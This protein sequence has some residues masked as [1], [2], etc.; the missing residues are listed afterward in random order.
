MD[1]N[2]KIFSEI[3]KVIYLESEFRNKLFSHAYDKGGSLAG[4]GVIMGYLSRPGLN[5][6]SRDM[7]LGLHGIPKDRIL[8]LCEAIDFSLKEVLK[9]TI[10]KNKNVIFKDWHSEYLK[11]KKF[12]K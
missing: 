3:P 11:Y 4:I 12:K 2:E 8:C 5:G 9:H 1:T 6:T 7:W 10:E